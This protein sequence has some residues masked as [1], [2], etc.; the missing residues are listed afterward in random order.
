LF[1]NASFSVAGKPVQLL[2][3]YSLT[4]QYSHAE[5]GSTIESTLGLYY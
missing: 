5:K 1:E 3:P 4:I 2:T